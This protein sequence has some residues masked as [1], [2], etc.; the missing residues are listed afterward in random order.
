MHMHIHGLLGQPVL[1]GSR[2]WHS[3]LHSM[4]T[5][6][7]LRGERRPRHAILGRQSPTAMFFVP[8]FALCTVRRE[9]EMPVRA[10][11]FLPEL[12]QKLL[13]EA[14]VYATKSLLLHRV[15][16]ERCLLPRCLLIYQK[17]LWESDIQTICSTAS[18]AK[19]P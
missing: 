3:C 10:L 15:R 17:S 16:S 7:T 4:T 2:A 8:Y 5:M 13:P 19:N 14:P 11:L 6:C 18:S 12:T 9:T 1:S